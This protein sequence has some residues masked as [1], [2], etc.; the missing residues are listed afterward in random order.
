[1]QAHAVAFAVLEVD[2]AAHA[3]GQV[4]P[5]GEDLAAGPGQARQAFFQPGAAVQV[6]HHALGARAGGRAGQQRAAHTGLGIG[7]HGQRLRAHGL[8]PQGRASRVS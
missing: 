4:H 7:Q 3:V 1:V 6:D 8:A 5:R 2:E